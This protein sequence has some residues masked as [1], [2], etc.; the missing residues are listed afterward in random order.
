MV[1]ES[2]KRKNY[3]NGNS[4]YSSGEH[5]ISTARQREEGK[6]SRLFRQVQL[7]KSRSSNPLR[8]LYIF[9]RNRPRI[10]F[11]LMVFS[12]IR[13]F[14][15][16]CLKVH[17]R[18]LFLLRWRKSRL[19]ALWMVCSCLL[20]TSPSPRDGLLSRMPSSA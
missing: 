14:Y 10:I 2:L 13:I 17:L 7:L 11:H 16:G 4:L 18:L 1:F 15:N 5:S 8:T 12:I 20:Y 3:K 9:I 6:K 19:S